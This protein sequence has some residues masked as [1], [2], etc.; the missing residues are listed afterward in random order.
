MPTNRDPSVDTLR[1]EPFQPFPE[2]FFALNSKPYDSRAPCTHLEPRFKSLCST[3][4]SRLWRQVAHRSRPRPTWLLASASKVEPAILDPGV[5]W[6]L[7]WESINMLNCAAFKRGRILRC[8]SK[9][10]YR[11]QCKLLA[12]SPDQTLPK[13]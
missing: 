12:S 3:A 1:R 8:S 9:A 11:K 5:V 7:T 4:L 13:F 10:Q 2:L 6:A